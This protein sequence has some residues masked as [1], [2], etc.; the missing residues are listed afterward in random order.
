MCVAEDDGLDGCCEVWEEV[1]GWE[2]WACPGGVCDADGDLF[3]LD[4]LCVGECFA[5]FWWV[6]VA[7]YDDGVFGVVLDAVDDVHA[8]EVAAV[9]GDV[10]VGDG[11][12][13]FGVDLVPGVAVG[14]GECDYGCCHGGLNG[15][16]GCGVV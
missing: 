8:D 3:D 1:F 13:Y 11:G 10:C 9:Y 14:V 7:V 15:I 6:G 5:D 12:A 2:L 4:G 16:T